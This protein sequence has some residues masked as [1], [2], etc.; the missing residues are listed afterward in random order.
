MRP[1]RCSPFSFKC[2]S[3]RMWFDHGNAWVSKT[4]E[5]FGWILP[6]WNVWWHLP[7]QNQFIF[8]VLEVFSK[9]QSDK[10]EGWER[11]GQHTADGHRPGIKLKTIASQATTS[12]HRSF[13]LPAEPLSA[14]RTNVIQQLWSGG[15]VCLFLPLWCSSHLKIGGNIES[16]IE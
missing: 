2:V 13:A 11:R 4:H 3:Q 15:F 8:L 5:V 1:S 14:S 7:D 9:Q 16:E 12:T 6:I 10:K